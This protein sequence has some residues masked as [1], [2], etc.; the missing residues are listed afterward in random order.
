M[1]ELKICRICGERLSVLSHFYRNHD[2]KLEEY[3]V[4]Y[5][6]RT[7]LLDKTPIIYKSPDQY[8]G[9]DFN[10]KNNLKKYLK[11]LPKDDAAN[12]CKSLIRKRV[13]DKDLKYS[14]LQ[15]ELVSLLCFPPIHYL[16]TLFD[17]YGF[18]EEIGL[19]NKVKP[20]PPNFSIPT[21]EP[22]PESH[23]LIDSRESQPLKFNIEYRVQ[24]LKFGDYYFTG[25]PGLYFER[26]SINDFLGTM[27]QGYDRFVKEL[28]RASAANAYLVMIIESK[29]SDVLSFNHLP[30]MKRVKTK[31]SPEFIFHQ[32]RS[33][34]QQFPNFQPIFVEGRRE[35]VEYMMKG[36]LSGDVFKQYDL[37]LLYQLNKSKS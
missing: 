34:I 7:D 4:K 13:L 14:P 20:M 30:W 22:L 28:D 18:C 37:Q 29:L 19:I 11:N 6:P 17:Y 32:L 16:S 10:N 25:N 3:I 35:A 23:I 33:L 36:F 15:I 26:K 31:A 21:S 12:Y 2:L 8:F 24:K 27:S 1:E 9:A 5:F